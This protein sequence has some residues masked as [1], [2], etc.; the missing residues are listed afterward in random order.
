MA[1]KWQEE[2]GAFWGPWVQHDGIGCPVRPG[3][4]VEAVSE[5]RFGY[6]MRHVATVEGGAYSSWDW[7]FYPELKRI[8][9]YR[10]KKPRGIGILEERL[11][12]KDEPVDA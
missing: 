10:E 5:D 11:V 6:T 8:L 7:S 2:N 4:I 12:T 1:T 3:T 9:R